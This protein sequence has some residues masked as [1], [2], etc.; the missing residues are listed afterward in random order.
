MENGENIYV[1]ESNKREYVKAVCKA[2]MTDLIRNQ[3][4]A[5]MQGLESVIPYSTLKHI[6]YR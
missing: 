2:K 5:F 6:N 1:N 3:S 4:K